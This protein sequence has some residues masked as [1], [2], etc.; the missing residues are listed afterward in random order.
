MANSN[1]YSG[2]WVDHDRH[3]V[4]G[5]T[6]TLKADWGQNLISAAAIVVQTIGIALWVIIAYSIHQRRSIAGLR[7]EFEA[8]LQ[9]ILR[10]CVSADGAAWDVFS[11]G[12]TWKGRRKEV[13]KTAG[14]ISALSAIVYA[15]FLVAGIFV[16]QISTNSYDAI[17]VLV[18]P[19]A[20]GF[21]DLNSG[22]AARAGY[23]NVNVSEHRVPAPTNIDTD[24]GF[25]DQCQHQRSTICKIV[26]RRWQ[27]R[28]PDILLGLSREHTELYRRDGATD[29]P[30]PGS[31][32]VFH[33]R[34]CGGA[35]YIEDRQDRE[36]S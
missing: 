13:W 18:D 3:P 7:D 1:I 30:D 19:K 9:V 33:G 5:A 25:A 31:S 2:L 6:I 4:L 36:S 10:N 28:Q 17:N 35:D 21:I 12:R 27:H 14:W 20:C 15:G 29:L 24:N 16:G 32:C 22:A 34:S 23:S 8:Q 26:L 11:L